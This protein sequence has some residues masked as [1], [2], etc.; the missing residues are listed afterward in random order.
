[1]SN[2]PE[3]D[4]ATEYSLM[5]EAGKQSLRQD[6]VQSDELLLPV[7]QDPRRGLG[8]FFWQN[9]ISEATQPFLEIIHQHFPDHTLLYGFPNSLARQHTTLLELASTQDNYL[10]K[11]L[12]LEAKFLTV[13][14]PILQ[15]LPPLKVEFRG[16][17]ANRSGIYLKGYPENNTFNQI[18]VQLRQAIQDANL[19]PLGRRNVQ[20]F[21]T[22]IARFI[23]PIDDIQKLLSI[24]NEHSNDELG[25][26]TFS[27]LRLIRASWPMATSQITDLANIDLNN[28]HL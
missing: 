3:F 17:V 16:F 9:K 20:I 14:L 5:W 6:G 11:Y 13:C 10:D 28:N 15:Q 19:P 21:H 25:I 7:D 22:T 1:M 4:L 23:K 18:R 24:I 12:E 2:I 8:W 26:D 27:D